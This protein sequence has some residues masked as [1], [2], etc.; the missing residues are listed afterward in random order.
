[1][2]VYS[3]CNAL[4]ARFF[5]VDRALN[6]YIMIMIIIK[7]W[8]VT[9]ICCRLQLASNASSLGLVVSLVR[10][11]GRTQIAAGSKTVIGIG[12]G[13]LRAVVSMLMMTMTVIW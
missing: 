8:Q 13:E 11:A 10:D 4:S 3:Y 5:A 2:Y 7:L 6:S 1:M 12:P 9:A